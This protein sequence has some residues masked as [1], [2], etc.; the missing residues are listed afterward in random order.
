M[1]LG[2]RSV[3][4]NSCAVPPLSRFLAPYWRSCSAAAW[5][6]YR[7]VLERQPPKRP[8]GGGTHENTPATPTATQ[9]VPSIALLTRQYPESSLVPLIHVQN[10]HATST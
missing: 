9:P 2:M 7:P 10:V 5:L 8:V 3:R 4:W 6:G 1:T